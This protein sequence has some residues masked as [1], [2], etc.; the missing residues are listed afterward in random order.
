MLTVLQV[1]VRSE[2]HLA[3]NRLEDQTP[4][5]TRWEGEFNFA[6]QTARTEQRW[7]K[8]I[9]AIRRHNDLVHRVGI[10]LRESTR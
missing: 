3:R 10:R 7:V 1:Y 5:T 8:R 6:V 9:R 4:F 2:V